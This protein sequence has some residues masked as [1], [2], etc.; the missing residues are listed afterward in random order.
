MSPAGYATLAGA[1][2]GV[3]PRWARAAE[4]WAC[5]STNAGTSATAVIASAHQ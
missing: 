3:E 4:R 1:D 5:A 2:T